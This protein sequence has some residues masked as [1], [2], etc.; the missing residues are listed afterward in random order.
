MIKIYNAIKDQVGKGSSLGTKSD[1][2]YD[3]LQSNL[4][5]A[6]NNLAL[7]STWD[8]AVSAEISGSTRTGI[9]SMITACKIPA[10]EIIRSVSSA[11]DTLVPS[12]KTTVIKLMNIMP[13]KVKETK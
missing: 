1:D 11:V 4:D 9:E 8:D 10:G 13:K 3:N 2:S 7:P 6:L 5:N 12:I